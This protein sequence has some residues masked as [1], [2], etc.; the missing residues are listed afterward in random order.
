M[1]I[2]K[3]AFYKTTRVVIESMMKEKWV[4]FIDV[5]FHHG[6][7]TMEKKNMSFNLMKPSYIICDICLIGLLKCYE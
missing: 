2:G 1:V 4:S 5:P 3:N 6:K 7:L